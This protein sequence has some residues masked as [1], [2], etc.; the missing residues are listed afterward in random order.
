MDFNYED[1]PF[2]KLEDKVNFR[3]NKS[4]PIHQWVNWVPG[5]SAHLIEVC[6]DEFLDKDQGKV[7]DPFMGVGT[8]LLEAE[9]RGHET[10]GF[11]INPWASLVSKTKLDSQNVDVDQFREKVQ[12]FENWMTK[13]ERTIDQEFEEYEGENFKEECSIIPD[14]SPPSGFRSRIDFFPAPAEI[15]VLSVFDFIDEI[16]S[17]RIRNLFRV[18]LGSKIVSFSNY[19]YEPSLGTRTGAGKDL[20]EN[21]DV[22]GPLSSK[23]NQ[24]VSDIK[25]V[26]GNNREG[27]DWEIIE[28]DLF[29]NEEKLDGEIDL[30]VTS[31]PYLNNYHYVRNT[32]PHLYW[33]GFGN[34]PS[35]FKYLS[36]DN[37]GKYWQKV[38]EQEAIEINF[39]LEVLEETIELI[40]S[41]KK[42]GST[43]GGN[44]WANYVA[45]YF[46][47]TYEF[48]KAF[49]KGMKPGATGIMIVGN[50]FIQG[51][52]VDVPKLIEKLAEKIGLI[53]KDVYLI[54]QKRVGT[55]IVNSGDRKE[56]RK[57]KTP[58]YEAAVVF[59]KE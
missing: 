7:C 36:N 34:D 47:D 50:S 17:E 22:V 27:K 59:E 43:Y 26:W 8:T 39:D 4:L 15:K 25:K 12:E 45:T 5:F 21:A 41:V 48:L 2:L 35:D 23:L 18:A 40:R 46:N 11:E 56:P 3:H 38:R 24:M 44:G 28:G 6:L 33:L 52:N 42:E 1:N 13:K 20:I 58:L 55:S 29:E 57:E 49:K 14:N 19:T 9:K 51:V 32:R 16:E 37:F 54:Q 53:S 30:I 31:P 10:L